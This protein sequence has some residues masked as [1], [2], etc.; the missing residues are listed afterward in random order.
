MTDRRRGIVDPWKQ[1]E[2]TRPDP[3]RER[4]RLDLEDIDRDADLAIPGRQI[5]RSAHV[6]FE[7]TSVRAGTPRD[8]L[9]VLATCIDEARMARPVAATLAAIG[10]GVRIA[11]RR[12]NEPS[13]GVPSSSLTGRTAVIWFAGKTLDLGMRD[14]ARALRAHAAMI[15]R[16]HG[17]VVMTH[18]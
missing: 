17:I 8:A 4:E 7:V 15:C 11:D 1:V 2:P 5:I 10:I 12:W 16:K 3:E 6:S 18:A 14:L 13:A 9:D